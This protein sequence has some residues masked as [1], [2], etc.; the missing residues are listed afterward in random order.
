MN[1][2]NLLSV[3]DLF[4]KDISTITAADIPGRGRYFDEEARVKFFSLEEIINSIGQMSTKAQGLKKNIT[5]LEKLLL[6]PNNK[7]YILKDEKGNGG[8]GEVIG[9]LK[10][11]MKKLFLYDKQNKLVIATPMCVL[12]FFVIDN[13]QRS[14]FGKKLFDYMLEDE[15][16]KPY[17]LAIDGP[18]PKML[19]FLKKHYNF[20][21]VIRQSNNFA[22]SEKFFESPFMGSAK[23]MEKMDLKPHPVMRR[24]ASEVSAV[25]HGGS[26]S[27]ST[28]SQKSCN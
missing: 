21:K 20:N 27:S 3:N 22:I 15:K 6:S 16:L 13:R 19:E 10:I 18:S 24:W 12:D 1:T 9:I 8:A 5:T 17:D 14:G 2:P 23:P 11:G 7:L 4:K 26:S 25:I 28:M